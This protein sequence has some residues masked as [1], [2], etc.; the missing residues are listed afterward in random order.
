VR[1][2]E[3]GVVAA[4]EQ[5]LDTEEIARNDP[6]SLCV[7]ELAPAWPAGAPWRWLQTGFEKRP[8]HGAWRDGDAELPQFA[9]DPLIAPTWI[10]VSE[11]QN[12]R[13]HLSIDARTTVSNL[14]L[15]PL[16]THELAMPTKQRRGVT[17][18]P[19]RRDL[20]RRRVSAANNAR[21]SR[22]QPRTRMLPA[23]HDD[24]IAQHEQL[25]ILRK[26]RTP[27]ASDQPQQ[28][29]EHEIDER[30]QH[31]PI[32][33]NPGLTS[34]S[35]RRCPYFWNPSRPLYAKE[36]AERVLA[37]GRAGLK[38]KTPE[39]TISALL[40]VGSKPGGPF[41][42]VDQGTY[43]S[44]RRPGRRGPKRCPRPSP[45]PRSRR[46]AASRPR[47]GSPPPGRERSAP[48]RGGHAETPAARVATAHTPD[49]RE[50]A[51]G[52]ASGQR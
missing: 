49:P 47:R 36:I 25:N 28:R 21:S 46:R 5:A 10:L 3:Q 16:A 45:R 29:H 24:L 35:K 7:H 6:R 11:P 48:P 34:A 40:A 42:R 52:A 43:T 44:P 51:I 1:D 14:R 27:T 22:T 4:Q 20:S 8:S 32:L 17:T 13:E 23:Q 39:A 41:T 15:S 18:R 33:P 19:T 37:S 31:R 30:K 38:G 12:Q 50:P 26:L 9:D 2:E